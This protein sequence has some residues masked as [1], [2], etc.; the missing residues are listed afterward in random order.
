V[1]ENG[2]LIQTEDPQPGTRIP[3]P[4]IV[5]ALVFVAL[6]AGVVA[7]KVLAPRLQGN[8][9]A[10]T[11]ASSMTSVHNDAVTDYQSALKAGK[12]IYVL[13]HSLS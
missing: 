1:T 6:L 3:S 11:P 10:R 8:T 9:A 2:E 7:A 5:I 4:K 13:F 12:P